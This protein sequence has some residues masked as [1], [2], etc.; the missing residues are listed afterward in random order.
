MSNEGQ[1]RCTTC[2]ER[3][4]QDHFWRAAIQPSGYRG[5]CILCDRK[6]RG[7]TT[8]YSPNVLDS[9][10]R[11]DGEWRTWDEAEFAERYAQAL[12]DQVKVSVTAVNY[13]F[14]LLKQH[15]NRETTQ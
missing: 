5:T 2:F 12:K 9:V 15:K 7:V 14:H 3:K 11:S 4:P 13:A 10:W 1:V 6:A 8:P